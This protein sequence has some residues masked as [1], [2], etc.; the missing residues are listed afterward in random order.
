MLSRDVI[1]L[2]SLF[3]SSTEPTDPT[4]IIIYDHIMDNAMAYQKK[5]NEQ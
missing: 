5:L 2:I 1:S 3:L 4:S